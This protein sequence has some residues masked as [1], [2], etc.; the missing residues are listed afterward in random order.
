MVRDLLDDHGR[1][2]NKTHASTGEGD[3]GG[4]GAVSYTHLD[5]YKRQ[6]I[7]TQIR[8]NEVE[9]RVLVTL[10]DKMCIRDSRKAVDTAA[11]DDTYGVGDYARE[12]LEALSK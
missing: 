6:P 4:G 11:E 9:S 5:V 7:D 12:R 8:N 3:L 1:G 10:R 2:G